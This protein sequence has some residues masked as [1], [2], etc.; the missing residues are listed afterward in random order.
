MDPSN[1]PRPVLFSQAMVDSLK[2]WSEPVRIKIVEVGNDL[3]M[4]FERVENEWRSC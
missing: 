2:N 3:I 1:E 4:E